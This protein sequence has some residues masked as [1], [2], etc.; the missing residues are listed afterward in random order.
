MNQRIVLSLVVWSIS[1]SQSALAEPQALS[2]ANDDRESSS[3]T[4]IHA[5]KQP[6]GI[7][8][9]F[10]VAIR[11]IDEL[12]G[13]LD[14]DNSG[15]LVAVDLASNRVSVADADLPLLLSFTHLT[16]LKLSGGGISGTGIRQISKLGGLTELSLLDAQV[17]NTGLEQ[18]SQLADLRSLSIRR[19]PLLNDEGI[20]HLKRLSKTGQFW[21]YSKLASPTKGV[22][23]LVKSLP[24]LRQIDLR[25]C[26]EVGDAGLEHLLGIKN[27]KVLRVGGYQVTDASLAIIKRVGTLRGLTIEDA[28]ITDAGLAQ[29]V[30]SAA[31]GNWNQPL[32]Q[33]YR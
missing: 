7:D 19:S 26:A 3:Y 33:Y 13:Q 12:D 9:R 18:I 21:G 10:I 15:K 27:I 29:L 6:D 2:A 22:A 20:E 17:D 25:G 16:K 30:G 1:A 24:Q 28:A 31:G 32:L 5:G 8:Q 11:R 4:Q 23:A 14:F